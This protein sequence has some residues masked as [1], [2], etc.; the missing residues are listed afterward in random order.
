MIKERALVARYGEAFVKH[1]RSS[2]GM[3]QV[4]DDLKKLR[5]MLQDNG[6]LKAFLE[7]PEVST[8]DKF[9]VIDKVFYGEFP[10]EVAHFVKLLIDHK[11]IAHLVDIVEYIRLKYS[12]HGEQEVLLKTSYPLELDL[13]KRIQGALEKKMNKKCKFYIELDSRILGGIQVIIG[14]RVMDGSVRGRLNDLKEKL[15]AIRVD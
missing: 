13:I 3:G 5:K 15:Q 1:A 4:I 8:A 6:D 11:R 14:N 7:S 12:H 9:K 10:D 2:I